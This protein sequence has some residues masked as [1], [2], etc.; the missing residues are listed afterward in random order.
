M[1]HLNEVIP[2]PNARKRVY[3][4]FAAVGLVIGSTQVAL[5]AVN[6]GQPPW[7]TATLAVYA[8]LGGVGFTVAQSNTS[9]AD[10]VDDTEDTV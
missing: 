3:Q 4:G 5:A 8:F 10:P 9:T 6:A 2:N 7:L 1:A